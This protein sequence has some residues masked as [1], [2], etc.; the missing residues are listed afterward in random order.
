MKLGADPRRACLRRRTPASLLA[1]RAFIARATLAN[2]ATHG[3]AA[4]SRSELTMTD[5]E[6]SAIAA[7]AIIGD[8]SW[9][10]NG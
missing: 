7:A 3:R 6:D 10:V 9:P 1:E 5:T 2:L 8:N 4:P